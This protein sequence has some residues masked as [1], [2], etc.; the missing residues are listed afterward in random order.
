MS[1]YARLI[2]DGVAADHGLSDEEVEFIFQFSP[3]H[4]VGKVAIPDRILLKPGPLDEAEFSLMKEHVV[5]GRR[6]IDM[7]VG[8]FGM[9]QL[10]HIDILRNIV[11]YHHEAWDG[12]GYPLGLAGQAIPLEARIAAVADVFDALTRARVYKPAWSNDEAAAYLRRMSGT[13]FY[14]P[15]V[16]ALLSRPAEMLEIQRRFAEP[17]PASA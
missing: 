7:M 15:C 14:T 4:D 16:D 6:I 2:A 13:K 8:E 17:G 10:P 12:S 1:R 9:D 3:L 5:K 11:S